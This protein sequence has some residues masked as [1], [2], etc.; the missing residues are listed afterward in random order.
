M[1]NLFDCAASHAV[2][3]QRGHADNVDDR[4]GN[5]NFRPSQRQHFSGTRVRGLSFQAQQHP[6]ANKA[7]PK[8]LVKPGD[9][10]KWQ[11]HHA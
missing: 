11:V 9:H 10:R 7:I 8:S 6:F 5:S 1:R 2:L 3:C 4:N